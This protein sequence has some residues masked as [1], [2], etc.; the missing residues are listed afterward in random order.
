MR[1]VLIFNCQLIRFGNHKSVNR[2]LF[3]QDLAR[4]HAFGANHK[5]GSGN[6]NVPK[7]AR[8]CFIK[9]VNFYLL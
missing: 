4:V 5:V 2:G 9:F 1:K 8:V 7:E 6:E 3:H